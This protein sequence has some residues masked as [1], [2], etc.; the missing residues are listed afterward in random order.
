VVAANVE[1]IFVVRPLDLS[2]SPARIQSLLTLAYD[3]GAL[4]VIALTKADLAADP[5]AVAEEIA[6]V[7]VGVEVLVISVVTNEGIDRLRELIAGR[8]VAFI[9]ESGGGKSTLTNLLVGE[10]V[11]AVAATSADGQGRHTTSHRE[12]VPLPGGGS[13]IDTPGMREVVAAISQEHV[14]QGFAEITELASQCR[15]SDCAHESE[16]GCAVGA[17]LADGSL[18]SA[19]YAAYQAALRDVAWSERRADKAARAADRKVWRAIERQRRTD[20]W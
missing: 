19:R 17:A 12:L 7:A 9:G 5:Y 20:S 1:V 8:T 4:P 16:P 2:T 14:D 3:S 10:D 15:F 13:I 18:S 6:S 11:L